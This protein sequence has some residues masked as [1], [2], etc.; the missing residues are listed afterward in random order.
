MRVAGKSHCQTH[1]RPALGYF[2]SSAVGRAADGGGAAVQDVGVDH[3]RRDVAVAKE[4]L[5][6]A[7]V[8]AILQQMGR[9]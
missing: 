7:D 9:E 1:S 3:G 2:L 4:L 5:D 6:G 8:V